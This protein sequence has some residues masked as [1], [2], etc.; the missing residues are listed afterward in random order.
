ME[1]QGWEIYWHYHFKQRFIKLLSEVEKLAKKNPENF[2]DSPAYKHF[3]SVKTVV[4][5]RI[6]HNPTDKQ[7]NLG[8]TLGKTFRHWKRAKK[9]MPPRYRVFFQY[10]SSQ[11]TIILA[12]L[13]DE[14]SIRR[15]GHKHDVYNVFKKMLSNK[16]MP[17]T[18]NDLVDNS[19]E[20][21]G[22]F[23]K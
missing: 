13:N 7:F 21:D 19:D 14:K 2:I 11:N 20:V 5:D 8:N 4:F 17:N 12:W 10:S 1:H 6:S 22:N 18:Y 15:D 9:E 3:K 16:T 23:M